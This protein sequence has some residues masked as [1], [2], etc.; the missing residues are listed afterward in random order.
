MIIT[1]KDKPHSYTPIE[2]KKPKFNSAQKNAIYD[3]L[4]D[5]FLEK[6]N[7][8]VYDIQTIDFDYYEI[9]NFIEHKISAIVIKKDGDYGTLDSEISCFNGGVEEIRYHQ[10]HIHYTRTVIEKKPK[11]R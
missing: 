11:R 7:S 3:R 4:E 6:F 5:A 10:N 1:L 2:L 9:R 8:A